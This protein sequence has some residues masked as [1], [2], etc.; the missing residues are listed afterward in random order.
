[1]LAVLQVEFSHMGTYKLKGVTGE[2]TVMQINGL[3]FTNRSFPKKAASSKAEMVLFT[4]PPPPLIYHLPSHCKTGILSPGIHLPGHLAEALTRCKLQLMPQS[5]K[6]M[7]VWGS[8][9]D[10]R[11]FLRR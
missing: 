4:S 2:Q 10:I 1:M 9:T 3:K 7:S 5:R 8:S 6:A 11:R